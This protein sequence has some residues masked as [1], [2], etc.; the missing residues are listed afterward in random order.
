MISINDILISDEILTEYFA[1]DYERCKGACCV[2]GESGAPLAD[3][4]EELLEQAWPAFC[5]LLTE[6]G[7]A[8]VAAKGFFEIDRDG[9]MVTP[10][11]QMAPEARK[12][13]GNKT[14]CETTDNPCAYTF[15][16]EGNCLCAVERT[17]INGG[18]KFK[19]PI[20]CRLYPIREVTFSDGSK[21]LN[22]HRWNLCKEAF[23]KG[24]KEGIKVYQFLKEPII[25]AYGA[26]FYAQLSVADALLQEI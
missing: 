16:E 20:S 7:K 3:G 26:D 21:A 24:K 18:C 1:C 12:V 4:E 22:L 8:A 15:F 10:L 23:E 5:P 17:H 11:M 19:K 14:L 25:D 2:I 9:D 6:S 13:T